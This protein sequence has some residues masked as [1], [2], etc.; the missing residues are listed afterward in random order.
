MMNETT[1]VF[2]ELN[3]RKDIDESVTL[4]QKLMK[5]TVFYLEPLCY[6]WLMVTTIQITPISISRL[7]ADYLSS[8]NTFLFSNLHASKV[9]YVWADK[10]C[11]E[12]MYS[13]QGTGKFHTIFT[14]LTVGEHTTFTYT[15]DEK[16]T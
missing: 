2:I 3:I 13:A 10:R 9:P 14:M 15:T 4:F 16:V 1:P 8:K 5:G 7:I 6:Y 12:V 11:H